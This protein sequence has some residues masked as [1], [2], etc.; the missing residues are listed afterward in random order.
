MVLLRIPFIKRTPKEI[1]R[2]DT[3]PNGPNGQQQQQ[4]P[5]VAQRIGR[6]KGYKGRQY[7]HPHTRFIFHSMGV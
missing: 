3:V 1:V 2:Y 5:E 4:Q 6:D 7:T